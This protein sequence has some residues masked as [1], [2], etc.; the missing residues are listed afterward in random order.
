MK[1][2]WF[3]NVGKEFMYFQKILGFKWNVFIGQFSPEATKF[4]IML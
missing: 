2:S 1:N 4:A 3:W